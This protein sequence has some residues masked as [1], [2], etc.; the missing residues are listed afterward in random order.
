MYCIVNKCIKT[1]KTIKTINTSNMTLATLATLSRLRNSH[2]GLQPQQRHMH[3][4]NAKGLGY[5]ALGPQ[6]QEYNTQRHNGQHQSGLQP[7][8]APQVQCQ[9]YVQK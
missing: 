6:R 2:G 5:K 4:Y 9:K 3:D 1:I 8:Q 7:Q